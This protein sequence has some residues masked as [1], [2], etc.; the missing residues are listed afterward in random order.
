MADRAASMRPGLIRP[1][2]AVGGTVARARGERFNEARADSPGKLGILAA[3]YIPTKASMR[4]GLIRPGN[5]ESVPGFDELV[6]LQ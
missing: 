1:G 3:P 2:N 6:A 4:P 5:K